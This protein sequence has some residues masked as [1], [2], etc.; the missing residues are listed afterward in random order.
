MIEATGIECFANRADATIHHVARRY[1][2]RTCCG[3]RDGSFDEKLDGLVVENME[4]VAVNARDA[5]VAVAHVFAQADV[6][7]D[8]EL[9]TM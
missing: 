7:D 5:A 6:G 8:N 4:M 3:V 9:W 1:H 2:V